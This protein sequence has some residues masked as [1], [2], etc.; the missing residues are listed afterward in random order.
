MSFYNGTVTGASKIATGTPAAFC[1]AVTGGTLTLNPHNVRKRGAGGQLHARKGTTETTL[2]LSVV[3]VAKTDLAKWFPTSTG[4]QVSD[5]PDFLVEVD[6]GVSGREFV[7]TSGQPSNC[8]IKLDQGDDAEVEV[9]VEMRFAA[10][11]GYA[12]GTYVPAYNS[13]KGHTVNDA[14]V[15][16]SGVTE[17][18]MSFTLSNDLGATSRNPLNGKTAGAK[19]FPAAVTINGN[20]PSFSCVT[21]DEYNVENLAAD[22]W[23]AVDVVVTLANGT[24]AEN[25]TVTLDD[26]IAE[27]FNFPVTGEDFDG[28]SHEFRPGDGTT[29]NRVKFA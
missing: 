29:Y 26:W 14:S 1:R 8:S 13:V 18:V 16:I 6:D 25:I 10:F 23:T 5:F 4:T 7:L 27:N 19:T 15:T 20:D 11:S 28:F 21:S 12:A 9:D 17:N 2:S 22:D 3:G 24:S